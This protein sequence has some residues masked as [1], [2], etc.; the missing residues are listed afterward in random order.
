MTKT[1]EFT[2]FDLFA[3]AGGFS[4]GFEQAGFDSL[5]MLEKDKWACDTLNHNF[6]NSSV[7]NCEIEEFDYLRYF[8]KLGKVPDIILGGPPCQGFSLC[9]KGKGEPSDP[10]NKLVFEFLKVVNCLKPKL[11]IIENVA[12]IAK[13]KNLKGEFVRDVLREE[14]EKIGY[15]FYINVLN[16]A[17]YGLPQNRLRCFIIGSKK[18]LDNPYPQITHTINSSIIPTNEKSSLELTPTLWDA[19]SDLPILNAGEGAEESVY[20][21]KKQSQYAKSMRETNDILF[22]HKAMKHSKRMIKRF[23]SMECGESVSDVSY[24]LRPRKR[25]SL[26]IS[27]KVYDQNNRRL[28]PNKP[29]NT[30]PASF[31]ANFVHPYQNRNFTAREGARI[32]SFPDRFKFLGKPTVVSRKL[33]AREGRIGELHLCQYNQIGNAVPPLLAKKIALHC[34]EILN[35]STW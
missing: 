28:Y 32:Q 21:N 17:D 19:I 23:E 34:R 18:S 7:I 16:A 8:N 22:N 30:I 11:F 6:K 31:Y 26:E 1:S 33:L 20:N 12:N 35:A 24:D 3:G 10:R 13:S 5:G 2:C 15:N 4:L 14:I 29:S 9:R 27:E 25:N